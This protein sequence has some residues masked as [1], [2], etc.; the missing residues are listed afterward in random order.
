MKFGA[1]RGQLY[2]AQ[3]SARTR[4]ESTEEVWHDA[5]RQEFEQQ[6]WEPMDDLVAENLRAMDQ[7]AGILTQVRQDCEYSPTN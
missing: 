4:W 6:L 3:K 2:D 5:T 1:H 7:L